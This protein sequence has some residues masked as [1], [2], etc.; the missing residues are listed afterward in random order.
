MQAYTEDRRGKE[1]GPWVLLTF[2]IRLHGKKPEA[3]PLFHHQQLD[4]M[5]PCILCL[6]TTSIGVVQPYV[7]WSMVLSRIIAAGT[8]TRGPVCTAPVLGVDGKN[9]VVVSHSKQT[10]LHLPD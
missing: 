4:W 3:L 8:G 6:L 2:L 9:S 7:I 5:Q 10:A 1:Q